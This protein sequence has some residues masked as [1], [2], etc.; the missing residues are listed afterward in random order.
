[1]SKTRIDFLETHV[2][3]DNPIPH[4]RSR[5]GYFPGVVRLASGELVALFAMGEAFDAANLTTHVTRS[6]DSGRTWELQG[7]VLDKSKD[8]VARTDSAKPQILPDGTMIAMGYW[9]DREDPDGPIAFPGTGGIVPGKNFVCFSSDD[10]RTWSPPNIIPT[11]TPELLEIPSRSLVL[12]SGDIVAT[13]GLFPLPDGT[14]PSGQF[15]VLLRSK[16][17]GQTW[18]DSVHFFESPSRTVAAYESHICEMQP[19]RLVAI[20]WALD[21]DGH[22]QL[23]NQVTV[24]HD[25][26]YTWSDAI[27]TGHGG[28]AVNLL[29]LG[30]ERLMSIHSHRTGDDNGIYVRVVDF[31]NDKW[32]VLAEKMVF[33][34]TIGKQTHGGQDFTNLAKALRFGQASLLPLDNGEILATH[35]AT[36]EGQ[37]RILT[38]RLRVHGLDQ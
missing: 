13:A 21:M 20:C 10:G 36:E 11:R 9:F 4:I 26:G 38:H 1:M 30:G 28:Q 37:G 8:S 7:P 16:D 24:S 19:G 3:Y 23:P 31:S 25:N 27:D 22:K 12:Q 2:V 6:S 15:G 34:K 17:G 14:N 33:G 5:H 29:Y 18:D 32:N 35:W